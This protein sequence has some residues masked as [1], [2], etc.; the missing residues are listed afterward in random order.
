MS[1]NARAPL[2]RQVARDLE[3]QIASGALE[4]GTKLPSERQLCEQYDVSQITIRRAL[5]ELAHAG[6]VYSQHGLGWFVA[7]A[8]LATEARGHVGMVVGDM[9]WP[10]APIAAHA[11][12][13]LSQLD[14]CLDLCVWPVGS[15]EP[16]SGDMVRNEMALALY[17]P[18][19]EQE[20]ALSRRVRLDAWGIPVL[21]IGFE[22]DDESRPGVYLDIGLATES[23]TE[24]L[25]R[26]GR[27][28]L[29]YLGA[30]P[31]STLGRLTYWAF[32]EAVWGSGLDLPL[33]WVLDGD[34]L[35]GQQERLTEFLRSS[36]RPDGMVCTSA[37]AAASAL[38][39]VYAA[40]LRCP[41]DVA[42]VTL[43][44]E[45]LPEQTTPPITS[46]RFDMEMVGERIAR[47][48]LRTLAGQSVGVE[49]VAGT[50]VE[51]FSSRV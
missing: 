19:G 37:D 5:R 46:Y 50:L 28:R 40:G 26:Q 10:L 1:R 23:I 48:A 12:A 6:K 21:G 17:C 7:E 45:R 18:M 42:L 22:L 41:N 8:V 51:R 20:D 49:R 15:H 3:E 31:T 2:Y 24:H 34:D 13:A 9:G 35:S 33:E 36:S 44:D 16:L 11:S 29:A 47:S 39:A 14:L 4:P 32:A 27:E 25:L 38:S 30:R 43:G